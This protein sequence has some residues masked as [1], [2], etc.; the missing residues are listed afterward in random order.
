MPNESGATNCKKLATQVHHM[1]GRGKFLN[2][3][4]TWLAVC[5][6]HHDWIHSH[7]NRARERGVLLF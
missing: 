3:V 7:P 1:R 5:P 2:Q 6:Y 4:D